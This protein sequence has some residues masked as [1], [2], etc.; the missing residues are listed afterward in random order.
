MN[1]GPNINTLQRSTTSNSE[2]KSKS[3]RRRSLKTLLHIPC[4]S[5]SSSGYDDTDIDVD[6]TTLMQVKNTPTAF[7]ASSVLPQDIIR[8]IVDLLSPADILSFSLTSSYLRTLLLPA[9]YD[10]IILRSSKHC[11]LTLTMLLKNPH[12]CPYIKKLAVRPNY[13]LAWPKSDDTL[14]EDWVVKMII[15]LSKD[16]KSM[17]TFD[18]DGLELPND[19][20]WDELRLN[21]LQLKGIFTNV[22]TRPLNSRSTL[23]SFSNLSSFSLIVRHGLGGSELFPVLEELPPKFWDMLL[24][25]CPDLQELAICS[26]S[27]SARVFNFERITQGRWPKLHTLT[28]GSFGYQSDFTLGPPGLSDNDAASNGHDNDNDGDGDNNSSL[29]LGQFLDLHSEIKYIRLLW[30]FKRWM[31]PTTVPLFLPSSSASSTTTT[32]TSSLSNLDTFIGIY[33]QLTHIPQPEKLETLDLTCEPLYANRLSTVVPILRKLTGLTSLDIWMHVVDLRSGSA[34][35]TDEMDFFR[36]LEAC[37]MLMDFHF[38]C[39]TSFTVSPLTRLL[40]SRLHLLPRLKRFSLT[41]GHKYGDE[42]MLSTVRRILRYCP[43]LVQVNIR[44]AREKCLNHLKQEGV[45]DVV[46]WEEG[47]GGGDKGKR[48]QGMMERRRPKTLMVYE[49]GIPLVG[50]PF[51]R[52]YTY[53]LPGSGRSKGKRKWSLKGEGSGEGGSGWRWGKRRIMSGCDVDESVAGTGT[54]AGVVVVGVTVENDSESEL[55]DTD[56]DIEVE[57]ERGDREDE[58]LEEGFEEEN[59]STS[60]K[61]KEVKRIGWTPTTN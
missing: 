4:S 30:N 46:E 24:H 44:W 53:T 20:F 25:R 32:T 5:R 14:D 38:M 58:E 55:D 15:D 31:S 40:L 6:P 52:R 56:I 39:T 1:P 34:G 12:L 35:G 27:S 11:R 45:Y 17:H 28:L 54:L 22:G 13:Y 37:P 50:K 16:L 48:S 47:G 8:D 10:T 42:T 51:S 21:C 43:K 23:F 60:V 2:F 3:N 26:F 18:W 33:Q 41:K 36:V 59:I 19:E 61:G 7:L 29:S 49:R 9:L 57:V